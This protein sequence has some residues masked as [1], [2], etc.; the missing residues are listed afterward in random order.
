MSVIFFEVFVREQKWDAI[1]EVWWMLQHI[2]I[3]VLTLG[4]KITFLKGC[5]GRHIFMI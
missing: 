5:E 1:L 3:F 4:L 2:F